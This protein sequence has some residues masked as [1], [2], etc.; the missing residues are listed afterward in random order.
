MAIWGKKPEEGNSDFLAPRPATDESAE[1]S[2]SLAEVA[3]DAGSIDVTPSTASIN[4]VTEE[5][6]FAPA[7]DVE[8]AEL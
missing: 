3:V 2:H 4:V 5:P 1:K 8:V 7:Q 6:R